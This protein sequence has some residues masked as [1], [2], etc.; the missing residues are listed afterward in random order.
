MAAAAT[1]AIA[2]ATFF[3]FEVRRF[4]SLRVTFFAMDFAFPP[5]R[6]TDFLAR[7]ADLPI[8]AIGCPP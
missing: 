7:L 3:F 5:A 1:P 4:D 8:P 6:R 2:A